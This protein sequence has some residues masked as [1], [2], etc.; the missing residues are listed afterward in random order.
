LS[1]EN[2][3]FVFAGDAVASSN[4]K[5]EPVFRPKLRKQ[6][7]KKHDPIGSNRIVFRHCYV[8]N[9]G[10]QAA[11]IGPARSPTVSQP[12]RWRKSLLWESP[13]SAPR[14]PAILDCRWGFAM[15]VVAFGTGND[16]RAASSSRGDA[17]A[18]MAARR[19][20]GHGLYRTA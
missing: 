3:S 5:W 2:S 10:R 11:V 14:K 15:G 1:I 20:C 13:Q 12:R 9:A 19:Q 16:R 17:Q 4:V 6:K 7:D 18:A 8:R